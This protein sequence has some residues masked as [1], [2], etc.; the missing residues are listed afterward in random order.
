M[1]I[2]SFWHIVFVIFEDEHKML[3]WGQI[4]HTSQPPFLLT[5]AFVLTQDNFK[6]ELIV[7]SSCVDMGIR[8][9]PTI[10]FGSKYAERLSNSDQL[11]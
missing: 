7:L 3:E 11:G 8:T 9:T 6:K 10:E 2:V 5:F 4:R 1:A